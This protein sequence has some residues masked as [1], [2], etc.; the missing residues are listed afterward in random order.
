[1]SKGEAT[2]TKILDQALL[3]ASRLGFEGLTL[4]VLAESLGLSKSGLFSHFRSK[5]ALL[6]SLFDHTRDRFLRHNAPYLVDRAPGLGEFRAAMTAWLDWIALP[7][8]PAGCPILGASFELEDLEG[9]VR[10][11]LVAVTMGSRERIMNMLKRAVEGGELRR[12]LDVA[13]AMFD[14]RGITLSFHLEHRLLR[15]PLARSH[16]ERAIAQFIERAMA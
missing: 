1:M 12:D 9:P 16:A 6:L 14:I 3:L 2:R 7:E 8:L 5:E 15:D 13:Q 4:G 10:D 11:R